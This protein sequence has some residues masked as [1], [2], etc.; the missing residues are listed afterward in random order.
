MKKGIFIVFERIDDS[1]KSTKVK[2][3]AKKLKKD[4][5]KTTL[6]NFPQH[7][8]SSAQLVD[9]YLRGEYGS[10]EI[11]S[12]YQASIFFACDRCKADKS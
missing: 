11:V 8:K 7:G 12:S 1:G 4:G 10:S 9:K 3:L 2:L 6:I 5:Y